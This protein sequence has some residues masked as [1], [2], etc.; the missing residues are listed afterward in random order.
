MKKRLSVAALVCMLG[1]LALGGQAQAKALKY[2]GSIDQPVVS[3]FDKPPTIELTVHLERKKHKKKFA[4]KWVEAT[5]RS[6][7]VLCAD[8]RYWT[9][10]ALFGDQGVLDVGAKVKHRTF[11]VRQDD[12][13][14]I[15]TWTG[16]TPKR[17]PVTGTI[18]VTET[19]DDRG[20]CDS[21]VRGFTANRE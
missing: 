8:G 19:G 17:G 3:E 16:R 18:Q 4:P 21:G 20:A 7:W 6:V 2:S 12:Y 13:G 15:T 9:T 5:V 14:E 1:L 11:S 10:G